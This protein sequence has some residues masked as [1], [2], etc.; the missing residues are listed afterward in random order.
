[1]PVV[2]EMQ[3]TGDSRA[4]SEIV[5]MIEHVLSDNQGLGEFQSPA[6]AKM[7]LGR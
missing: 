2:I 1:M 5:A 6:R 3:N 7:T 4:H